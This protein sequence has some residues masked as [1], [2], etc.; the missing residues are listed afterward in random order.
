MKKLPI[1]KKTRFKIYRQALKCLEN[2]SILIGHTRWT[3]LLSGFCKLFTDSAGMLGYIINIEK[4]DYDKYNNI[5]YDIE[6][7]PEI[8]ARK[9]IDHNIFWFPEMHSYS[10]LNEGLEIRKAILKDILKEN[11]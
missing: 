7:Y 4:S 9:P 6:N 1:N 2:P 5:Y 11:K 8:V 3:D 10:F